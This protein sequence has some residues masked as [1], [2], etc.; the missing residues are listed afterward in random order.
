MIRHLDA[1][2]DAHIYHYAAYENTAIKKLMRMHGTREN[3]VDRLLREKKLVDLYQVVRESIRISEPSYSI[4]Y[5]E[6]FYLEARQ[7][8]VKSGGSSIVVYEKW[9]D[10]QDD[11]ILQDIAHYN[12]DDVRSTYALQ[13]WLC[14]LRPEKLSWFG[15]ND[16]LQDSPD[17]SQ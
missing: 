2:P 4:K 11:T 5:V 17:S 10:T 16:V 9:R 6:K 1:Y 7:G 12:E 13:Q 15:E 8:D 14:T 3:E